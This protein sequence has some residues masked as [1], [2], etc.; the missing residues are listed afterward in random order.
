MSGAVV[1]AYLVARGRWERRSEWVIGALQRYLPGRLKER[2]KLF[3][4]VWQASRLV[5]ATGLFGAAIFG[6]TRLTDTPDVLSLM[7]G[8]LLLAGAGTGLATVRRTIAPPDHE[9]LLMAPIS[10][11]R[12][13]SLVFVGNGAFGLV[14]NSLLLP[15][16]SGVAASAVF[17][18]VGGVAFVQLW[19]AVIL[20]ALTGLFAAVIVDRSVGF[21]RVRRVRRGARGA[22][23]VGYALASVVLL[24]CG[25]L[26]G[27]TVVPWLHAFPRGSGPIDDWWS[28]FPGYASDAFW[29][30]DL[31]PLHAALT[32]PMFPVG[33]LTRGA[34]GD[35]AGLLTAALWLVGLTAVAGGLW[36]RSG[37]WYRTEWRSGWQYWERGDLFDLAERLY[38]NLA[39]IF[40]RGDPLVETQVRNLCR[41][42]EWVAANAFD[43][44]GSSLSW[45]SVGLALGAAP[46]L[47]DSLAAAAVFALLVGT[48]EATESTRG[49]FVFFKESLVVDAEGRRAGLYRAAGVSVLGLYRA[50]LKTGRLVATPP[51]VVILLMV[52][53]FGGLP[54]ETWGLLA[55]A[56]LVG[57]IVG[58]HVELLPGL[59]SPHF[60][61][62]H[63]DEL[64]EYYEQERLSSIAPRALG[65]VYI[66]ELALIALFLS[67]NV[68]PQVFPWLATGVMLAFALVADVSLDR[69]SRQAAKVA[70]AMDF[71]A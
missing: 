52:A 19:I 1:Y 58:G 69:L 21:F 47:G 12:A 5:V 64:G 22:S 60:R 61:W 46:I 38:T 45:I 65:V 33:A 8:L 57:W 43:L 20:A 17:G 32:H 29:F 36:V 67:G 26:A 68:P 15:L 24:G 14:E 34:L 2:S 44:L 6:L 3:F 13:Y 59:V 70:D 35:A 41:R 10:D 56:G 28:S 39:R 50:K 31:T 51:L 55:S 9:R 63:P 18:A 11:R 23:A 42:R 25:W 4:G 40:Y 53:A 48:W 54:P 49:P 62:D 71:S 37:G 7:F 27:R 66:A 16:V 30:A